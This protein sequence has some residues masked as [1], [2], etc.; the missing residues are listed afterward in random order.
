MPQ[1][2]KINQSEEVTQAWDGTVIHQTLNWFDWTLNK[3][4]YNNNTLNYIKYT[5]F[6]TKRNDLNYLSPNKSL[7][8]RKIAS[9]LSTSYFLSILII[10]KA[11]FIRAQETVIIGWNRH[12]FWHTRPLAARAHCCLSSRMCDLA[13]ISILLLAAWR[14]KRRWIF[15]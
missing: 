14:V 5:C 7:F 12:V 9:F 13:V 11:G 15:S 6:L 8:I 1:R 10:R 2:K 4:M 3:T